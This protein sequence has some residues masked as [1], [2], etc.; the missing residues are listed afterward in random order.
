MNNDFAVNSR[1]ANLHMLYQRV[2]EDNTL[3]NQEALQQALKDRMTADRRFK[4]LFPAHFE[5]HQKGEGVTPTDYE[6]YRTLIDTYET[7][8]AKFDDYSMKYMGVLA[9]ECEGL[10]SVPEAIEGSIGK[11]RNECDLKN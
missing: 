10:K 1:D 3:E 8:C 9:A 4:T 6:C 5:A 2:V 11:I 7:Q